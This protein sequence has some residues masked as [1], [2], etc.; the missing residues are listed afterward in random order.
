[1]IMG[2]DNETFTQLVMLANIDRYRKSNILCKTVRESFR[3]K[4]SI[5]WDHSLS[6]CAKFSE[7]L[8]FLIFVE[9]FAYI[10]NQ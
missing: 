9:N 3:K 5:V 4:L 8:T 2:F 1:M 10:L 6:T 7:K